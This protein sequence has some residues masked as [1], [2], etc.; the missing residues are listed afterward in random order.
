[1]AAYNYVSAKDDATGVTLPRTIRH[2]GNFAANW[3]KGFNSAD[4]NL[5][6]SAQIRSNRYEDSQPA[7]PGYAQWNFTA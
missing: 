3:F 6:L 7:A 2:S 5:N 4:L 1:M